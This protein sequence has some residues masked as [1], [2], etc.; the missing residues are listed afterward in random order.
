MNSAELF[1]RARSIEALADDVEVAFDTVRAVAAS[2]DWQCANADDVRAT[3][4]HYRGRAQAAAANLRDEAA[5][6][7]Q[8]ARDAQER[9]R[10]SALPVMN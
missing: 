10:E 7:R 6:V 4:T 3:I 8:Q 2:P 9:E 5:R 1:A